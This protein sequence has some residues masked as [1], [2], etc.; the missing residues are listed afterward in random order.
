[1]WAKPQAFM[2][3][4]LD[5]RFQIAA[6]VRTFLEANT[7]GAVAGLKTAV[8]SME[9]NLGVNVIGLNALRWKFSEDEM[10]ERRS[11]PALASGSSVKSRLAAAK[12]A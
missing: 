7:P 9:A 12:G 5:L 2:W 4:K 11:A 10:S 6:Y 8:Q 3:S 1:M